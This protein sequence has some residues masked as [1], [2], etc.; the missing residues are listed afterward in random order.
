MSKIT[1]K[2]GITMNIRLY[3]VDQ[4]A[5]F[6][7][8]IYDYFLGSDI[9]VIGDTD[10]GRNA[11]DDIVASQPDFVV[12][13]L[14]LKGMDGAQ[15]IREVKRAM[16]NAPHFIIIT[17]LHNTAV[18]EE[19]IEAGA[20]YCISKPCDLSSLASKIYT[21]S[22]NSSSKRNEL[23]ESSSVYLESCVTRLIHKVGIPAHIKGYQYL[24]T[25]IIKTF[26]N[27]GIIN[28]VTKEL[29]PTIAKEYGTTSSRVE[30]AIRHAIELAWDRGDCD[31]LGDMFGYTVQRSKGKPTNSEFIALIADYL[32]IEY[33][34]ISAKNDHYLDI[35]N[36]FVRK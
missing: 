28:F 21:I 15:L 5:E 2:K 35:D 36:I 4:N 31:V 7:R 14:W 18:L 19:A 10:D 8:Q 33:N 3:A 13:D 11:Y 30:R 6:K 1:K 20:S 26:E 25:A 32:R 27:P 29:Y 22:G 24:R 16:N 12:L 34:N 9:T 17:G 23:P